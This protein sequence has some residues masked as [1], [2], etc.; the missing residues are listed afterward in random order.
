M[1]RR[2][3]PLRKVLPGRYYPG[4]NRFNVVNNGTSATLALNALTVVQGATVNFST[5]GS[6]T[7]TTAGGDA[8]GVLGVRGTSTVRW[9]I[10]GWRNVLGLHGYD[11]WRCRKS[12]VSHPPVERGGGRVCDRDGG[13]RPD[14]HLDLQ[15]NYTASGNVGASTIRFNNPDRDHGECEWQMGGYRRRPGHAQMTRTT[16]PLAMA[17]GFPIT[18]KQPPRTR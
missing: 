4:E 13:H 3:E 10:H 14:G 15:A 16:A 8:F 12:A 7:T 11:R 2:P 1:A 9:A 5:T 17:I 6:I 18:R